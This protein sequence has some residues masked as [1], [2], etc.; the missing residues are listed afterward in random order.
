MPFHSLAFGC[1]RY[2]CRGPG[3][4][5]SGAQVGLPNFIEEK[6]TPGRLPEFALGALFNSPLE[7]HYGQLRRRFESSKMRALLSFQDLYVGEG[8]SVAEGQDVIDVVSFVFDD[9][10]PTTG[11]AHRPDRTWHTTY[12]AYSNLD[13]SS[14]NSKRGRTFSF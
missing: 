7:N 5:F 1:L 3:T 2:S 11:I 9:C 13:I 14:R 10:P 6:F 12:A 4:V 8:W